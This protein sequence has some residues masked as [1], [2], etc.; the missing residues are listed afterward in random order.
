MIK[1]NGYIGRQCRRC[2][3]I[4]ISPRPSPDEVLNLYGHDCAQ[5]SA[6][7]HISAK[8]PKQLCARHT[9]RLLTPFV[10]GGVLLEI[11]AGSGF[12]L[13]EARNN[14]FEP[15]AIE[16][17]PI[18]AGF[19]RKEL[20]IPCEESPLADSPFENM[21]FDVVYHCDVLS[22]FADP[23]SEFNRINARLKQD[24]WLVFETGNLGEVSR[25]YMRLIQRFQYPDHLFFFSTDNLRDLLHRTGF[26]LVKMY[27]YSIVLQ[28]MA[29]KA[30]E[31]VV[32]AVKGRGFRYAHGDKAISQ[33]EREEGRS[34]SIRRPSTH[35]HANAR[36][37][38]QR[39]W[40]Y[41]NYL[42]RYKI[43]RVAPKSRRPQT[44]IVIARKK[45]TA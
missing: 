15:Y 28:L 23:I 30:R 22:H 37:F 14:G 17:N 19:I 29:T 18:Q 35:L 20:A 34:T 25:S 39:A 1:E 5:I 43:G 42:L 27:R 26:E 2:G 45:G 24:G 12:F 21:Q 33:G 41:L 32:Q 8:L 44:V 16:L 6:Y 13:N 9:L 4:F 10:R 3:L 38:R 40:D 11:G 7:S 36:P 31:T